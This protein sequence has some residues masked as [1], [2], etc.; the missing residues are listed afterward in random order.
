MQRRHRKPNEED[1][2]R[3]GHTSASALL[4]METLSLKNFE[5]HPL[6]SARLAA[7]PICPVCNAWTPTSSL[8]HPVHVV[9]TK[10]K[11]AKSA[12]PTPWCDIGSEDIAVP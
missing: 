10:Q 11:D 2:L 8:L 5:Q 6:D 4:F 9:P 1:A 3:Y 12:C 7:V